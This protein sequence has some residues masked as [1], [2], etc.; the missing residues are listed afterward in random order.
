MIKP[1][2]MMT[3]PRS[4]GLSS[5]PKNFSGALNNPEKYLKIGIV[6]GSGCTICGAFW[7][8]R[9]RSCTASRTRRNSPFSK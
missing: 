8:M 9:L 2:L 7:I 3:D 1:S 6:V 4:E 5:Q